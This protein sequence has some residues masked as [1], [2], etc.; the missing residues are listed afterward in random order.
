MTTQTDEYLYQQLNKWADRYELSFYELRTDLDLAVL[1]LRSLSDNDV[2]QQ[3]KE[4][5]EENY[6]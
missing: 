1:I 2:K 5:I 4:H 6:V 3:I